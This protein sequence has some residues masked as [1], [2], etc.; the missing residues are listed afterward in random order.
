[1]YDRK[2][3]ILK[4]TL[5]LV[6]ENTTVPAPFLPPQLMWQGHISRKIL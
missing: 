3:T 6:K 5:E 2:L 4:A 1:M